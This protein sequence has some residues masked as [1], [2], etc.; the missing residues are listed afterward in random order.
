L[1]G[2]AAVSDVDDPVGR[3][4][5][6]AASA[7]VDHFVGKNEQRRRHLDAKRTCCLQINDEFDLSRTSAIAFTTA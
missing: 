6:V 3:W 7:L 1:W 5:P 4:C 2:E